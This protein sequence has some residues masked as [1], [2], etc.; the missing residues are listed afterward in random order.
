VTVQYYGISNGAA[1]TKDTLLIPANGQQAILPNLSSG[2]SMGGVVSSDQPLNVVVSEA[3]NSGGSAYNV[4]SSTAPTLYSPLALNGQYGFTTAITIFNPTASTNAGTVQFYD[5]NGILISG[6]AQNFSLP[7]YSSVTFNQTASN[8]GLANNLSYWA[9]ISGS[10]N[11]TAQVIE[12]GPGN[13]VATFNALTSTQAKT[14]LYA[15]AVFNRAFGAYV[16]GMQLTNP[17]ASA[18]SVTINYYDATGSKVLPQSLTIPGNGSVGI[19]QPAVS[20]LPNPFSGSATI[21]SSL[22]LVTTVNEQAPG[23]TTGT[24]IS[25]TYTGLSA[26]LQNVALPVMANGFAGFVSG[27]TILNVGST[28]ATVRLTYYDGTGAAVGSAQTT[29]LAP[30][31]SYALYQGA[32]SQGLPSGFFG[33]ALIT[34]N[35]PLMATTNALNTTSG[36]FY[37]YN[38]PSS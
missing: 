10:G 33:T 19:F 13:F 37:T 20:G 2:Q 30:N 36:L 29:Q 5:Q 28:T 12:F 38:E 3:L 15:P 9:K 8:S 35:V 18:A 31:A 4:S 27:T 22:P 7:G 6:A 11:L 16:T 1:G 32:A 34:S 25:G 26:G 14:T 23:V 24:I 17:N 21:V